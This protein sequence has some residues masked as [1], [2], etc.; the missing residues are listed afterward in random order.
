MG[1]GD[2]TRFWKDK[3][4]IYSPLY[5][6]FPRLFII[7]TSKDSMVSYCLSVTLCLGLEV[8]K[9]IL[10]MLEFDDW[11]DLITKLKA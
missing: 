8:Q 7:V 11:V 4:L 2:D 1:I 3:W 5:M 6:E 10:L 9:K